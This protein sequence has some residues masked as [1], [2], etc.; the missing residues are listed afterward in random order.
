MPD[1]DRVAAQ[2]RAVGEEIALR[3]FRRLEPGQVEQKTGPND[4]VTVADLAVER[5]LTDWLAANHPD[6]VVLGEEAYAA[7]PAIL[8]ILQG[9]RPVWVIDPIDGTI[10]FANGV[11]LF[12][13]IVAYVVRGE[14]VMG[15]IHDP[16]HDLTAVA[17]RGSGAALLSA[18]G[19][20]RR[21]ARTGSP[22]DL[23]HMTGCINLRSHPR[24]DLVARLAAA[25]DRFS[26][27]IMLRCSGAEHIAMAQ[28]QIDFS[29]YGSMYPWDHAAGCLIAEEAG[30]HAAR[31]DGV[32]Y[33]PGLPPRQA[34]P[35]MLA[36]SEEAWHRVRRELFAD[37]DEGATVAAAVPAGR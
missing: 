6:S 25:G 32:R 34:W 19:A 35:L 37:W 30:G 9:D 15:W 17:E 24:R 33:M 3:H 7:D 29:V 12:A 16:V 14:T 13:T 8:G 4:L 2:I 26:T 23:A 27:Q 21:P 5:A 10:N 36:H 22:P 20:E 11:P 31:L 28:G 18:G 1:I